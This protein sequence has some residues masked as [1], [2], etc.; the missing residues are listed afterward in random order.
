MPTIQNIIQKLVKYVPISR[1]V[2]KGS[3]RLSNLQKTKGLKGS[4]KGAYQSRKITSFLVV[5]D[6]VKRSIRRVVIVDALA[7]TTVKQRF[8][9]KN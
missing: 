1:Y 3:R 2:L 4:N 8:A 5:I 6:F 7:I 9:W